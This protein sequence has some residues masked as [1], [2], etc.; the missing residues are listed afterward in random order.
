MTMIPPLPFFGHLTA[1]SS[2]RLLLLAQMAVLV[3][4]GCHRLVKL[5]VMLLVPKI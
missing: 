3:E 4:T 5:P 1:A 2:T